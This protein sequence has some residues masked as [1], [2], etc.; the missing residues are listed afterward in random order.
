VYTRPAPGYKNQ[1]A[2][3]KV[4]NM[5]HYL[6]QASYT[7]EA[8]AALVKN[9]QNRA[10]IV[11]KAIENMGGKM[12]GSWISFGDQDV[13]IIAE[14]PDN[15]SVA[16]LAIAVAAGGSLKNTKTTPLLTF[17]EG[18]AALK[19]AASSTYTPVQK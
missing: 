6:V 12:V 13:V 10:E 2:L 16:A 9:P 7:T 5:A 11:S 1:N 8:L 15:I 3:G 14:M 17:E 19:K 4:K 18:L